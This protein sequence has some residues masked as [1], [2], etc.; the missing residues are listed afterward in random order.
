MINEYRSKLRSVIERP[1][2]GI[3]L[4]ADEEYEN[5]YA[6][7]SGGRAA[8]VLQSGSVV[9]EF[10][11]LWELFH[12]SEEFKECIDE[13]TKKTKEI[14]NES[15][16]SYIVTATP[17]AEELG[18]HVFDQ[19]KQKEDGG[20]L[21]LYH[22]GYYPKTPVSDEDSDQ[23]DGENIL[24]L[25]D[26][27]ST[28]N[29]IC[30]MTE[31]IHKRGGRVVG[32]LAVVITN[33]KW[34]NHQETITPIDINIPIINYGTVKLHYLTDYAIHPLEQPQ[35]Y[36]SDKL[37]RV[38]YASVLPKNGDSQ[39]EYCQP[40]F[41]LEKTFQHLEEAKAIDFGFYDF[42][43]RY[44]TYAF[45][46]PRLLEHKKQEIWDK[47]SSL[48][49][50]RNPVVLV[51]T[52]KRQDLI[53]KEFI[54]EQLNQKGINSTTAVTLKRSVKDLPSRNLTL[55]S[56]STKVAGQ[57][58]LVT[59]A[60]LSTTE[61]LRS[62]VSLLVSYKVKKIT[63]ICLL[64]E[65]GPSTTTFVNAI[66]HLTQRIRTP[67]NNDSQRNNFTEFEFHVVYNFLD[68]GHDDIGR[69]YQEVDRLF[70]YYNDRTKVPSFRRLSRRIKGY[71]NSS[72]YIS[73]AYK[74][75][76]TL[77]SPS[78]SYTLAEDCCLSSMASPE[79]K[80]I[81]ADSQEGKIGLM[82]Y[83][84]ALHRDFKPIIKEI[85]RAVKRRTFFH[86]YGLILSDIHYLRFTKN[87]KYLKQTIQ[88]KLQEVWDQCFSLESNIVF[89]VNG[90]NTEDIESRKNNEN[91]EIYQSINIIVYLIFGL[92][93]VAHYQSTNNS[94]NSNSL[95]TI[96]IK[97]LLFC[98]ISED[99]WLENYP[100]LT[101]TYFNEERIFYSISFLLYGLFPKVKSGEQRIEDL[102]NSIKRFRSAFQS[103]INNQ[104]IEENSNTK[105]AN[106]Q[107][108]LN[109]FD[110]ILTEIGENHR[111]EKHQIIRYLQREVLRP[112]E[113]HN[114]IFTSLNSLK[115][116][117]ERFF[118]N[119]PISDRMRRFYDNDKIL[120]KVDET[121]NS[122]A[123]L[124]Y[125]VEAAQQLFYFTP[126]VL[127]QRERYTNPPNQPNSFAGD[128]N[129]LI[130]VL[131]NKIRE[132]MCFSYGDYENLRI[133]DSK[134]RH[135][136]YHSS[137]RQAL[138]LYI[139]PLDEI[140]ERLLEDVNQ[141]LNSEK[142]FNDLLVNVYQD[143]KESDLCTLQNIDSYLVLC[144]RYLLQETLRN[145]FFNLHYSF[146]SDN[147]TRQ[148]LPNDSVKISLERQ[149]FEVMPDKQ[150][151]EGIIFTMIV[152]G[153]LS[154]KNEDLEK[155][156]NT[157]ADQ[158]YKLK[159]FGAQYD[160]QKQSG[161]YTFTI[162]FISRIGFTT[163]AK[164]GDY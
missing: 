20:V 91:T 158:L 35:D 80:N 156:E 12:E 82:T 121:L 105:K 153:G 75:E 126:S 120:L 72:N 74:N 134:I 55:G 89:S 47:I 56:G 6:Q 69:I 28:S 103:Q 27:V 148:S 63:V 17:V 62:L 7:P 44:Y 16:Y 151:Q 113:T 92:G 96:S 57:E 4:D 64:N 88:K 107:N 3:L 132:T 144:E 109:N 13:L 73:R 43:D 21:S 15:Y 163:K 93:I 161:F 101:L 160:L 119:N 19:L 8:F 1:D 110:T 37:I 146:P 9:K 122:T 129:Q 141:R 31:I 42:E 145:I 164:T 123:S 98:G 100:N 131:L 53:F 59:L 26:V 130:N 97:D 76:A 66:K 10:L 142:G 23:L 94:Y 157:I 29:L 95:E 58:V 34:I 85:G 25:T 65:M 133:I 41:S 77:S 11:T 5:R 70:S 106:A 149:T 147:E 140:I 39:I 136:F 112:R 137:L 30:N 45:I 128:V 78:S 125:I 118:L 14:R 139:V 51:T 124:P 24:L 86:L 143:W 2:S 99:D 18:N 40:V 52:Y 71:F 135:D 61:K 67:D 90:N 104:S 111:V 155:P 38:D 54:R 48:V 152:K 102:K 87:L 79:L 84:L 154:P 127:S 68:I 60:N 116:E 49:N 36:D 108:V 115:M 22:Y 117:L 114:P 83:N 32:I 46:L 150:N 81:K 159:E 33:P 162:A 50:I 138:E